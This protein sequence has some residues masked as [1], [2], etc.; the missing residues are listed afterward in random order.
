[1]GNDSGRGTLVAAVSCTVYLC[2]S[3]L[4]IGSLQHLTLGIEGSLLLSV[5]VSAEAETAVP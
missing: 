2:A 1:M 3:R 5:V 4:M